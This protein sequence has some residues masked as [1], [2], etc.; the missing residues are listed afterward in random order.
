MSI[1]FVYFKDKY[2]NNLYF[3]F[4]NRVKPVFLKNI[5]CC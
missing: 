4:M 3:L 2:F 1:K 5:Y